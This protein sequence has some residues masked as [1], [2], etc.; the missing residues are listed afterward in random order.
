MKYFKTPH[1]FT[2]QSAF[3]RK[4]RL[5]KRNH[6]SSSK[7]SLQERNAVF[8]QYMGIIGWTVH[9]NSSLQYAM[10][11]ESEDLKQELAI[12]LL[13]AIESY[14]PSRGAKPSTY[15]FKQLRYGLLSLWRNSLRSNRK[16]NLNTASFA[17]QDSDGEDFEIEI[18]YKDDDTKMFVDE[19]IESLSLR[20][21]DIISRKMSGY[22]L[23]DIREFKFM[24]IIKRKAQR[25]ALQGGF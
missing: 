24:K 4:F 25:F 23:T 20:E 6:E 18:P 2:A 19:F 5:V 1:T 21:R 8:E 10:R 12:V 14:D 9:R 17:Y 3:S 11:I 15:Y 22:E 7:M 16:A 13:R